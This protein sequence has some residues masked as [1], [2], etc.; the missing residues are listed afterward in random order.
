MKDFG[1]GAAVVAA[2]FG[3][4]HA[5]GAAVVDLESAFRLLVLQYL[6]LWLHAFLWWDA[7]GVVGFCLDLRV[8]FG[9]AFGPNRFQRVTLILRAY[10]LLKMHHFYVSRPLPRAVAVWTA[11][12]S[13]LQRAG[14]LPP[15]TDQVRPHH[16]LIYL[17][18]LALSGGTDAV[19]VPAYLHRIQIGRPGAP[20]TDPVTG[21]RHIRRSARIH[22]Y[23]LIALWVIALLDLAASA[24]KTQ[25]ATR[26]IHLGLRVAIDLGVID[27]PQSK[28]DVMRLTA[29]DVVSTLHSRG[30]V[31]VEVLERLVGRLGNISQIY[32]ALRLWLAAGYA[33]V[34]MRY[35]RA[36]LG[37]RQPRVRHV[38][39]RPSG[40]RERELLR[41][42]EIADSELG[43]NV[44]APL[45]A[46]QVFFDPAADGV[47]V[48]V[49][50]ASGLDGVGGYATCAHA[51]D[52]LYLLSDWWPADI[53]TALHQAAATTATVR[54][55]RLAMPAAEL[56][57]MYAL[58][59]AVQRVAPQRAVIAV[60]DCLPAVRALL[61]STSGSAQMRHLLRA[62]LSSEAHWL[63][64]HVHRELNTTAGRLS[65]PFLYHEVAREAPASVR[66]VRLHIDDADWSLLRAALEL[67]LAVDELHP[68]FA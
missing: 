26:V 39:L 59:A 5:V 36:S 9:G 17:D 54:D 52:T 21:G 28:A 51:P 31:D 49:T 19:A 57:G 37:R 13:A 45:A 18:D 16:G 22:V 10:V 44:G 6:D 60:G 56:F 58:A 46:A 27:C 42:F 3:G 15:G 65:H 61:A 30:V 20:L 43:A 14:A 41:L 7:R 66:V 29:R 63:A 35:Q 48:T 12:R 67:P 33:L 53:R 47:C 50:D 38:R 2:A 55:R 1:R 32:A 64:V 34:R 4:L 62:M 23:A 11:Q 25:C 40:R 68:A 8:A 24:P